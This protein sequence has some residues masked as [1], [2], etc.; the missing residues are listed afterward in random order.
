[1]S[2][3]LERK[4]LNRKHDNIAIKPLNLKLEIQKCPGGVPPD[5]PSVVFAQHKMIKEKGLDM[6][7]IFLTLQKEIGQKK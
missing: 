3:F 2:R 5:P 7:H 4:D 1:M 6:P